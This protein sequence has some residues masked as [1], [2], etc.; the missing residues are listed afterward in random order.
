MLNN[1]LSRHHDYRNNHCSECGDDRIDVA[2][3]T[4]TGASIS[5]NYYHDSNISTSCYIAIIYSVTEF[6]NSFIQSEW[7]K[8]WQPHHQH[9]V[10]HIG[11]S[12][13]VMSCPLSGS[14]VWSGCLCC[15]RSP[16]VDYQWE[17][18][19]H[20]DS[21]TPQTGLATTLLLVCPT[22]ECTSTLSNINQREGT[23]IEV[24]L[25][26]DFKVDT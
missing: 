17:P 9:W 1:F 19:L 24:H 16:A 4:I 18:G 5:Y 25:F 10:S 3:A 26:I 6:V 23:I 7:C 22:V 11:R 8:F 13:W 21:K 14:D 12:L 20:W 15:D 2:L